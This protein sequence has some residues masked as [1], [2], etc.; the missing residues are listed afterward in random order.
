MT[1]DVLKAAALLLV[2][3]IAQLTIFNP[4]EVVDGSAD[5]A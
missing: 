3:S 1:L 5:V 2:L 4:L